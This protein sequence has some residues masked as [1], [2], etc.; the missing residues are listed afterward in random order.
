LIASRG[1]GE[2]H[3]RRTAKRLRGTPNKGREQ[4]I[5]L[6]IQAKSRHKE[7]CGSDGIGFEEL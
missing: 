7:C 5:K 4:V 3:S 2:R 1:T 6:E